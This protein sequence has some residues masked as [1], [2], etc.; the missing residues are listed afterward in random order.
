MS[1]SSGDGTRSRRR[2][3][4]RW[5]ASAAIVIAVALNVVGH[6]DG[7][8]IVRLVAAGITLALLVPLF[9]VNP[10][11]LDSETRWSRGVSITLA[12]VLTVANQVNVV[13]VIGDLVDGSADGPL[14]L[15]TALQVWVT[16]V[17][18]YALLYWEIDRG[19]PVARGTLARAE[20]PQADFAFP[21]DTYRDTVGEVAVSSSERAD[22]RP[23]FV[24]YLYVS[25]TNTMAF[26]P[27]DTMP[28]SSRVKLLMSLEGFTGFVL[29]ALVI[30]RAVNILN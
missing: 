8:S 10:H 28:L 7:T 20:L 4:S 22:W 6:N 30:S 29:L 18:A 1:D 23:G 12:V 9:V 15:L 19:G 3:E 25:T 27:T 13:V 14:L 26:S 11:R 24:D 16:N 21:Q 17:V 5:P 2:A